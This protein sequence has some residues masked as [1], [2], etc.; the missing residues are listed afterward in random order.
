[1]FVLA[2]FLLNKCKIALL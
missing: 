2:R 1:M